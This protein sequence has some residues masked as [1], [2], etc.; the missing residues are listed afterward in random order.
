MR[1]ELA[2]DTLNIIFLSISISMELL[3]FWCIF[4]SYKQHQPLL[5]LNKTHVVCNNIAVKSEIENPEHNL[6]RVL[7]EINVK[8]PEIVYSQAILETGHFTSRVYKKYNNLFGLYNSSKSDY[9]S[10]STWQ[11]SV[12]A[13]KKYIQYKLHKN[14]D[15]YIFLK[16]IGYA[17]DPLYI[18]KIKQLTYKIKHVK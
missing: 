4:S 12:L 6:L 9:Y 5:K 7:K 2:R 8:Y 3:L 14:E 16:R 18:N 10:F 1:T 15:Y 13:Y 11:E 17:E